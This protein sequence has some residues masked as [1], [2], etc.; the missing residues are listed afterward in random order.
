MKVI[1]Y[2]VYV[3][4]FD[5]YGAD[6]YK[7]EMEQSHAGS[8]VFLEGEADIGEWDDNHELN[9]TSSGKKVYEKYFTTLGLPNHGQE[10]NLKFP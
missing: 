10:I 6:N 9:L 7:I 2:T 8:K 3:T 5:D 1:K 4:D